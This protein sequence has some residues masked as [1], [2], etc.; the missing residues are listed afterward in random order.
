MMRRSRCRTYSEFTYVGRQVNLAS[1]KFPQ[2]DQRVQ[3]LVKSILTK[4]LCD[5]SG[6]GGKSETH[7]NPDAKAGVLHCKP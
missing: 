5:G 7:R 2:V 3:R 4:R 1:T 6:V